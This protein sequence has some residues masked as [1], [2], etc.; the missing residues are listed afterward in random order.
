EREGH[1]RLHAE[2]RRADRGVRGPR[3]ARGE[4]EGQEVR[5]G[6]ARGEG[7]E[8]HGSEGRHRG[9]RRRARGGP[10]RRRHGGGLRGGGVRDGV[11]DRV[12]ER[13]LGAVPYGRRV[14]R[15]LRPPNSQAWTSTTA[16]PSGGSTARAAVRS[17]ART[18]A[19]VPS[20]SVPSSD[21]S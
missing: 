18:R 7:R 4:G 19:A 13:V 12:R 10:P 3:E 5:A 21:I 15:H 16:Y 2:E 20:Q 8:G 6:A 1:G 9:G 14:P 17:G 11:R